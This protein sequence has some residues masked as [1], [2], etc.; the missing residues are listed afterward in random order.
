MSPES[1]IPDAVDFFDRPVF[2]FQ[3]F[4]ETPLAVFTVADAAKFIGNV[5]RHDI[6]IIPV[7]FGKLCG[8]SRRVFPVSPAVR[9][10]VV[11]AAEFAFHA[12]KLRPEDIGI[13]SGHP[14]G[15]NGC[16]S[17]ETY[18]QAVPMNHFHNTVEFFKMINVFFRL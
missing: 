16:G 11:A 3:P 17:G 8:Q 6:V 13:F 18:F 4:P 12:V 7:A 1:G 15:M 5:P 10:G 2:L 9:T 14:G